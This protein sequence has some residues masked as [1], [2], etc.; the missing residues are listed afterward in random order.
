MYY[1]G[2][3]LVKLWLFEIFV[4]F[5][6]NQPHINVQAKKSLEQNR[7]IIQNRDR[8]THDPFEIFIKCIARSDERQ[9]NNYDSPR[10][11]MTAG[12]KTVATSKSLTISRKE[13]QKGYCE[14]NLNQF[15][16]SIVRR[17]M[18]IENNAN[19]AT[20]YGG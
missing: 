2:S 19:D 18:K 4:P 20:V 3:Y 11:V 14:I 8:K 9:S 16:S 13:W 15:L 6:S 17:E 5:H 10:Y 7:F 1:L 12:T